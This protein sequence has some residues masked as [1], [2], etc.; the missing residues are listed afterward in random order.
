MPSKNR[1]ERSAERR[2]ESVRRRG[3]GSGEMRISRGNKH[4]EELGSFRGGGQEKRRKKVP[5]SN[6]KRTP[7]HT[8]QFTESKNVRGE[9]RNISP[10]IHRSDQPSS[11]PDVY[12]RLTVHRISVSDLSCE[13]AGMN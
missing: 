3:R 13:L 4:E 8:H 1:V 12:V 10:S 2:R 9:K 6:K 11:L 7:N 5:H